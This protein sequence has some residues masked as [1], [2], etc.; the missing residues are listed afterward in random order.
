MK[1]KTISI[2]VD[3]AM[4]EFVRTEAKKEGRSMGNWI[5]QL[6][7]LKRTPQTELPFFGQRKQI[8]SELAGQGESDGY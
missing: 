3:M 5:R 7:Q 6:I 2:Q 1:D 8:E 4:Y